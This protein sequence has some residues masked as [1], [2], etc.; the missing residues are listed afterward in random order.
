M[1]RSCCLTILQLEIQDRFVLGLL[2]KP[3]C[4][5]IY[6]VNKLS[7]A[8][9]CS[10]CKSHV[11]LCEP[12]SCL[13]VGSLCWSQNCRIQPPSQLYS[14]TGGCGNELFPP[15]IVDTHIILPCDC[16]YRTQFNLKA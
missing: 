2:D 4:A 10:L 11:A 1:Y 9:A 6:S 8:Y 15:R 5:Y 3:F 16:Q 7:L 13:L 14:Y 12:V